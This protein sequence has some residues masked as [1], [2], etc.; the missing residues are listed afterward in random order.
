ML[1]KLRTGDHR[2]VCTVENGQLVVWVLAVGNR[3]DAHHDLRAL[4]PPAGATGRARTTSG[5]G[6]RGARPGGVRGPPPPTPGADRPFR[7]P[8]R[9]GRGRAPAG[10]PCR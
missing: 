9:P 1:W 5:G 3:R 10:R 8:G 7:T 2:A 6:R 4:V